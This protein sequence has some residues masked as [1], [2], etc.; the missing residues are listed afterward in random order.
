MHMKW[1]FG[2]S[3]PSISGF[4]LEAGVNGVESKT[5]RWGSWSKI[6]F[7]KGRKNLCLL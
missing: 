4:L 3:S 1:V 6:A 7:L 5:E 2:K